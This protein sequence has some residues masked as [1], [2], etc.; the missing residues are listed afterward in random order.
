MLRLIKI[1]WHGD[2]LG[3]YAEYLETRCSSLRRRQSIPEKIETILRAQL[4]ARE[5]RD[6]GGSTPGYTPGP[7]V[8]RR[9]RPAGRR[10][11]AA[12]S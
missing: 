3:V 7:P 4:R 10:Q 2:Y 12:N 5:P 11:L 6:F 8:L 9:Q 1:L